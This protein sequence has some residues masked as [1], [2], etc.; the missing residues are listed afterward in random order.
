MNVHMAEVSMSSPLAGVLAPLSPLT[1]VILQ[2][3]G[4]LSL[5]WSRDN[6]RLLHP[7]VVGYGVGGLSFDISFAH[8]VHGSHLPLMDSSAT[9]QLPLRSG[10]SQDL[11]PPWHD[12]MA[13]LIS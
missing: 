5:P 3:Q 12:S 13:H 4:E 7:Q 10:A 2:G 11:G 9:L 8:E 1:W 6:Q